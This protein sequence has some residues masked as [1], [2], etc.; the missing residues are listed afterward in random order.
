ML[1]TCSRRIGGHTPNVSYCALVYITAGVGRPVYDYCTVRFTSPYR[2]NQEKERV[3]TI[4][5]R[6]VEAI[7]GAG[8][9]AAPGPATARR[10]T[11]HDRDAIIDTVML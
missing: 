3:K 4:D 7:T 6:F 2:R 8:R 11:L 1:G 10:L 9:C 5:K